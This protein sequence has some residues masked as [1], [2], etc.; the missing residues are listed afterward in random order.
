LSKRL[1]ITTPLP[2]TWETNRPFTLLGK[3]CLPFSKLSEVE[4]TY[5]E[6]A[7]Y[8]WDDRE[9]LASDYIK[10]NALYEELLVDLTQTMNRIHGVEHSVRYWRILMGPWL[11]NIVGVLYDRWSSIEN[12]AT[13]QSQFE[14]TFITCSAD[15]F[16]P[17]DMTDAYKYTLN[18]DSWNHYIY[19]T[20]IREFPSI[21][22][23]KKNNALSRQPA[24]HQ[25]AKPTKIVVKN[26]VRMW[27]EKILS[28]LVRKSD[29]FFIATFLPYWEQIKLKVA[30]REFP[31]IYCSEEILVEYEFKKEFRDWSLESITNKPAS[32]LFEN[33][34][35]KF[36][37]SQVPKV[38]LEGYKNQLERIK[39]IHWQKS[40]KVI[41]TS[42][43]YHFHD[44]FKLWAAEKVEQ[45]SKLIIGQHGG[46][47][48]MDK[49]NASEDHQVSIPDVYFS[50][51]WIDAARPK[52]VPLGQIKLS[53]VV[54]NRG[55]PLHRAMLIATETP[56]YSYTMMS[57][58][59]AGQWLDYLEDQYAFIDSLSP[60]IRENFTLRLQSKVKGGWDSFERWQQQF[61]DLDIVI[62]KSNF[63]AEISKCKL[64]VATCN[65]GT[66]LESMAMNIPTV[67]FWN[68]EHWELNGDATKCMK[69]L[70]E[71]G[72]FH[73]S[74]ISAARHIESIWDSVP[75]WWESDSVQEARI[76]FC[77]KYS[78]LPDNMCERIKTI[79]T[80][81]S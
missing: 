16:I 28:P 36:I 12:A 50:W 75:G 61:P 21:S 35:R 31:I 8:H 13:P 5:C 27:A 69:D 65:G 58:T 24:S 55:K 11:G 67:I 33:W 30:L 70:E 79:I 2:Q 63:Y 78:Y 26:R 20:I 15:D 72:I 19:S 48:G 3:W 77:R 62:D 10:I 57:A 60:G 4:N 46:K 40:P 1:L 32:S 66:Y 59:V 56:R 37:S 41:W 76:R 73:S 64:A 74:P 23:I 49:W 53:P 71:T 9:L 80:K 29:C 68:P 44:F 43:A 17:N 54:S 18:D 47:F 51:G 6:I 22:V 34:I 25:P 38:Y 81:I 52:I 14:T 42:N 7:P 39:K 45:G